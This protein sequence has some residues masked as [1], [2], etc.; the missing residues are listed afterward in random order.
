MQAQSANSV[1]EY[2]AEFPAPVREKLEEMR[3][4]VGE[5]VPQGEWRISYRMPAVF[6]RGIVV[7]FGGFSRH[8]GLF[9]GARAVEVFEPELARYKHAR[10]SIQLPLDEPLPREL[11]ARIV[12]HNVERNAASH[13]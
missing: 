5:L 4:L 10:G 8:I 6:Y 13:A 1:E 7:W 9:P 11:I 2:I 3:A 12:R